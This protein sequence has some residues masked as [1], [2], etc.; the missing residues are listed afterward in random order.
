MGMYSRRQFN[1]VD[2]PYDELFVHGKE[3]WNSEGVKL[4]VEFEQ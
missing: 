4:R 3:E 2:S 1:F